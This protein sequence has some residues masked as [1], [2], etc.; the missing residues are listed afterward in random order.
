MQ[1]IDHHALCNMTTSTISLPDLLHQH[2][3]S[4][5]RTYPNALADMGRDLLRSDVL[6]MTVIYIVLQP[7]LRVFVL[8]KDGQVRHRHAAVGVLGIG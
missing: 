2:W 5:D 3:L 1:V 6:V 7:I 8:G 4:D